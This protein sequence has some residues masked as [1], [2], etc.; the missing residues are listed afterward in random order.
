[1]KVKKASDGA[2]LARENTKH[3]QWTL[4]ELLACVVAHVFDGK[5][6]EREK[7]GSIRSVSESPPCLQ[8]GGFPV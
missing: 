7:E 1:M 4:N 2:S 6:S 3:G 5:G 8:T